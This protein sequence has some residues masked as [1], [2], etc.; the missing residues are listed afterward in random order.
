MADYRVDVYRNSD[1][2]YILMG[3]PSGHRHLRL[4][5]RAGDR[6]IVFQEATVAAIVRAYIG[7]KAHPLRRAVKLVRSRLSNRKDG[8]AEYQLIEESVAEQD[9]ISELDNILGR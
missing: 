4:V 6:Y 2:D 5:I 3:V 8:Y 1:I 7:I 9:I